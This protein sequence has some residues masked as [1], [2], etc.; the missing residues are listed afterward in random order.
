MHD[1]FR[2]IY[3]I[4]MDMMMDMIRILSRERFDLGV[5]ITYVKI[6]S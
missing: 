3:D 1:L 2:K 6:Y 5:I 4:H